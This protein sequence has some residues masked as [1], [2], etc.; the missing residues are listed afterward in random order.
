M[1]LKG[2]WRVLW[3][4]RSVLGGIRPGIGERRGDVAEYLGVGDRMKV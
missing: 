4:K 3:D 1:Y 2:H